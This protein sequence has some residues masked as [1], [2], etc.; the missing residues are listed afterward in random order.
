MW[1]STKEKLDGSIVFF[2]FTVENELCIFNFTNMKNFYA[3][4]IHKS[5]I[6]SIY[7][8]SSCVLTPVY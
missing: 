1:V 2:Q 8:V 3:K 7:A 5:L 4:E 6:T